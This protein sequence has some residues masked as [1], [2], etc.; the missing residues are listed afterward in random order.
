MILTMFYHKEHKLILSNNQD[1]VITPIFYLLQ[2]T[3]TVH[4]LSYNNLG[5]GRAVFAFT[6]TPPTWWFLVTNFN[7]LKNL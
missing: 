1:I 4:I 5:T 7:F 2:Q 6:V 3:D